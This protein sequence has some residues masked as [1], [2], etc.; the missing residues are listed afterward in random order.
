MKP[1]DLATLTDDLTNFR[2]ELEEEG[3][4]AELVRTTLP[5]LLATLDLLPE[6]ARDGALLE[7]GSSPYF[8]SVCL[9]RLCRG[10]IAHGNY[11]GTSERHTVDRLVHRRSGEVLELASDLFNIETD[12]FPYPDA[13]FDVVIFSELIEHL[14]TNPV[15]TLSEIHRVLKPQGVVIVTTPNAISLHRLETFLSAGSQMVDRYSPLFGSGARH[16]REYHPAELRA[17]LESCGFT[18]EALALRD[19]APPP[20]S[21][22]RRLAWNALLR[23]YGDAPRQEHIFLRAR[24]GPRFR[25][26][27][28]TLLFDNIEFYTLV[29][30]PWMEMGINDTIQTGAGWMPL[31]E[32]GIDG[33]PLK[34]IVDTGQAFLKTPAG[35]RAVRF[36][37]F[38]PP[39]EAPPPQVRCVVWDRWLGRV[40]E[41]NVYID[42]TVAVPRGAWQTIELPLVRFAWQAGDE[43][44]VRLTPDQPGVAVHRVEYRTEAVT[45]DQ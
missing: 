3:V 32:T 28:P 33:K 20:F 36:T 22:W 37:L 21:G 39:A 42:R 23:R 27:F 40:Q 6:T 31:D 16:N 29:R 2:A 12:D 41:A 7:L 19:L 25:W 4:R 1:D 45:G 30:E 18:I 11:F 26:R 14:S 44:E 35:A 24:R 43:V 5:R 9:R 13:S 17:L 34:R 8:L 10:P 15:R 38:A